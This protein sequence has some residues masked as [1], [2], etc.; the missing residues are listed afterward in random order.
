MAE[1][2]PG[3]K[4]PTGV[5]QF[6]NVFKPDVQAKFYRRDKANNSAQYESA[7]ELTGELNSDL[8][9]FVWIAQLIASI[10]RHGR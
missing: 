2:K 7:K 3:L 6:L 5:T 4:L 9:P 10:G 8:G 1:A